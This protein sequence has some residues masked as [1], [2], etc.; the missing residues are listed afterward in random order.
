MD[1][2]GDSVLAEFASV[3]EAVQE[4]GEKMKEKGIR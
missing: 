3:V 1:T 4:A 2:A